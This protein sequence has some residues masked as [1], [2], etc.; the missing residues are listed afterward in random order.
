MEAALHRLAGPEIHR[1]ALRVTGSPSLA[2]DATQECMLRLR[3]ESGSLVA[4]AEFI[5]A[6]ERYNV[7]PSID[8][9]VV[10]QALDQLV[11]R[12]GTGIK[13]YTIAV[14]L[15]GTSLNDERFLEYLIAELSAR[16]LPAGAMCFEI[17]ETAAIANLANVVYFMRELKARG[18][19]F[20]LDDFGSGLSSFMYLKTLPVDYLKIDG[21]FIHNLAGDSV[22]QAMVAAMIDLSRS[23][24]FRV[25]AEQV[26]DQ[27]SLDA[28]IAM[29]I[30]FVQG[31]V[32]GRPLPLSMAPL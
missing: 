13:P 18:C 16:D 8:R 6:A 3:D 4:P 24:N 21:S 32:V 11:H 2:D 23:L 10:R 25:V 30:D 14:N 26:E 17:T 7:M 28:V 5:P 1:V 27:V 9:W 31:F 15:S 29:G 19:H 20:A 22:N 12:S